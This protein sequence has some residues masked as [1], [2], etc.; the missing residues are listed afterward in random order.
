MAICQ[1]AE[2]LK[3]HLAKIVCILTWSSLSSLSSSFV[4]GLNETALIRLM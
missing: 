2:M 3:I 4:R 1:T